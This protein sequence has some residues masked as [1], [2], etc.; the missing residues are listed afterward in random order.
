[1]GKK[2]ED[3]I[4][5]FFIK[6]NPGDWLKDPKLSMC[7]PETRGIW[8]DLLCAMHESSRSGKV[9]GSL[10]QLTQVARCT[11]AEMSRAI[12]EL[13]ATKTADVTVHHE[14]VTVIN[15]RMFR[16]AKK[17]ESDKLRQ[18]RHRGHGSVTASSRGDVRSYMLDT[19]ISSCDM[20][21]PSGNGNKPY[22]QLFEKLWEEYPAHRRG[23]FEEC[24]KEFFKLKPDGAMLQRMLSAL[25]ALKS[26]EWQEDNGRYV[27]G[28]LKW[29]S[30]RQWEGA[31]K[32]TDQYPKFVSEA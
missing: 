11:T 26:G 10:Q 7:R 1:M 30:G 21:P 2:K 5:L 16:D 27:P 29:I 12:E 25:A 4:K 6:F 17:R 19:P 15:R 28:M 23:V 18:Q 8:M 22:G 14:N 13:K 9:T 32:E 24:M 20:S 3:G 31:G